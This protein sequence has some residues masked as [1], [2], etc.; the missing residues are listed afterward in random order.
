[1]PADNLATLPE[2]LRT[3]AAAQ[4]DAAAVTCGNDSLTYRELTD[5][6]TRIAGCLHGLG[7]QQDGCVGVFADPSLDLVVSVWGILTAGSAYLPLSP[8]Y[9]EERLRYII[10]DARCQVILCQAHLAGRLR[11]LAPTGTRIVT[12]DEAADQAPANAPV[13]PQP[14][15]LAYVIYT[16][17]ST[18]KPKGVMV[19]HRSVVAQLHWLAASG[20]LDAGSVILQKT[21]MSFDAAQW[22]IL[23]AACGAHVVM[24]APGV[25]RDPEGLIDTIA[26]YGVTTLQCV[27]TLLQALV[28][29]ERLAGCTSLTHVFSGGEALTRSLAAELLAALP[30]ARLVNLYGPTECTINSSAYTVDPATLDGEPAVI[31]IGHPVDRTGYHV[32]DE[33]RQPVPPGETGELYI[34]GAQLARGYLHRPDLT[35]ERFRALSPAPGAEPVRLYKTGDLV[36]QDP[37]GTVHFAGRADSQIKLRGYRVELDEI[38]RTIENHSWVKRAAVIVKDE[39]R[40]GF[41]NLIAAVE[42]NPKEAALMDQGNHGSH[43]QSKASKLQVKAQLS[44]P[45]LREPHELDGRA[46]LDLPGKVPSAEQRRTA[47][48]RK[49]YRFYEGGEVSRADILK[50]LDHNAG[51]FRSRPLQD[52]T[53]DELGTLLRNFGQFQ[54]EER[55][56]P[57]YVYASPGALYATQLYL[58]VAGVAGLQPG[59]YYHNPLTHQLTLIRTL[60]EEGP[61]RL[62]AHFI[63]KKRAIEPVYK[64]NL[65]EVLEFETGH[66]VGLFEQ[67]LPAHG[68]AIHPDGYR[69]E[70]KPLFDVADEDY[71]LGTFDIRQYDGRLAD[72]PT[73]IY[74]Q[75]HPGKVA[76]L[77]A[78]QYRYAWGDLERISDELVQ[79]KHVIAI[80]QAVY[81]RSSIGISAVSRAAEPWLAYVVLG[82]KLHHLQ[83]NGLD[84]GFMS[85]GYSSKTGNPLPAARRIDDILTAC[86]LPTGAS[87]FFVGGRVSAEQQASEGMGEDVV[88]MKGPTEMIRDDLIN[89]LPDYML[90]NKVVVLDALPQTANGKIDTKKLAT[91]DQI[92]K[93]LESRAFVPPRTGTEQALAEMWAAALKYEPVSTEDNFFESGGNSLTAVTLVNRISRRFGTRLPVQVLFEAPTVGQLARRIDGNGTEE[94]SRL[95]RLHAKGFE[96]P[97]FCWPG[98]GG[99]PM[100]L[101]LLA[102]RVDIDRP[103]YGIQAHGLNAG[104]EPFPTIRDMAAA[105]LAEIRRIQPEG[106]YTLWGYSFG[107][108]VAFEAAWQLEQVGEKVAN[109]FLICPGNPKVRT[110]DGT[111]YGRESSYRNPAYLTVL[112]SV[113]AGT[114]SGQDLDRCLETVQDEASFVAFICDMNPVLDEQLVRRI[115]RIVAGTYEFEYAFRELAERS[116]AA[117]VTLFKAVGDDYSFIE[118]S[119]GY[120][121]LPPTVIDLKGGHYSVLR[122]GGV[123]ELVS[124]IRTRLGR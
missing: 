51:C 81:E 3:Q 101:Q 76:D 83:A 68:L 50:L 114:I 119:S 33:N 86:S 19:E 14:D 79:K 11:R 63:G 103:I 106:P 38:A 122:E 17:G 44:N 20:H 87:Y 13:G 64:N 23:A 32:L 24:G 6:S 97:V 74:V 90:P 48:A 46:H 120:S 107:A 35:A 30:T 9:P 100:N 61:V 104:E 29:T 31:P 40:T 92:T 27:P 34:S 71:Y 39:P 56:L 41:Q 54:S 66:M 60:G 57:K 21:P 55:L 93:G 85:S 22:E 10:E 111:R 98:L 112:F 5:Q 62:K 45:G 8:D 43:H 113:F 37:D 52:V 58:E 115:T 72:D 95:I 59:I 47:F 53:L 7:V 49:T 78:G 117:P 105:D 124:A 80:N 16:S 108:R 84:F 4:P 25:F 2:L 26:G 67:V 1:M 96:S 70:L 75:A 65:L 109:L 36:S 69:P 94:T 15:S 89:Y 99:Y 88:H 123:G 116:L 42:F 12:V 28:D 102:S 110:A 77:P 121:A 91:L 18:G 82:R 73:E 118:G